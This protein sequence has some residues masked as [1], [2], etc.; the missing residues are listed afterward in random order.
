MAI[1]AGILILTCAGLMVTHGYHMFRH[2]EAAKAEHHMTMPPEH[3]HGPAAETS[4]E[5]S[6]EN[7]KNLNEP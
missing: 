7:P 2:K 3:E 6:K 1:I 4:P 5:N